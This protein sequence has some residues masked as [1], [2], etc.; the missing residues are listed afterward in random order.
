MVESEVRPMSIGA[1]EDWRGG[2]AGAGQSSGHIKRRGAADRATSLQELR[3]CG[4]IRS[5]PD[6]CRRGPRPIQDDDFL[7]HRSTVG[8]S[9]TPRTGCCDGGTLDRCAAA[10]LSSPQSSQAGKN[11]LIEVPKP[12][13]VLLSIVFRQTELDAV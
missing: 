2:V 5:P 8:R 6:H 7:T 13:T 3:P 12:A 9:T 11:K 10:C 4:A 1:L